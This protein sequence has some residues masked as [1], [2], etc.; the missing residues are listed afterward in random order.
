ME[1]PP[2]VDITAL[3]LP[4]PDHDAAS[5]SSSDMEFI[6][7]GSDDSDDSLYM[8]DRKGTDNLVNPF[9]NKYDPYNRDNY[10]SFIFYKMDVLCG[11]PIIK[12]QQYAPGG[13]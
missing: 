1:D 4:E 3:P 12:K 13:R 8:Q 9:Y 11:G 10:N 5:Q 6:P 7:S 2:V